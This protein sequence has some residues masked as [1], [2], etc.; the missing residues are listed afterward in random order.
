MVC[1]EI[2]DIESGDKIVSEINLPNI[3]DPQKLI[4]SI[5][6]FRRGT[7]QTLLS[8]QAVDDDGNEAAKQVQKE[9][10]AREKK[11]I[12][13]ERFAKAL[14]AIDKGEATKDDL[15]KFELTELQK[16]MLDEK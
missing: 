14:V 16:K 5:T 7:L 4:A 13:P 2:I 15:L 10:Q 3:A 11:I 1:T 8:L 9:T 12:T 6:Y